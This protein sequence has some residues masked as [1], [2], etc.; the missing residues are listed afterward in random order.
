M[1]SPINELLDW[2]NA[3]GLAVKSLSIDSRRVSP[4]DVF[5]AYPGESSDGRRYIGQALER[6]A[7]AVLWD[8]E[9]FAWQA[10]IDFPQRPVANLRQAAGPLAH[11]IYGRPSEKLWTMG[12]TGTNGKTS[13]SQWL[14]QACEL[15][16]AH[17]AVIGTLGLGFPGE[18]GGD[19]TQRLTPVA[20]TTPDPVSLHSTFAQLLQQGGQGVAMEVSSIG[21]DQGRV[22]GVAFG[23][24][25]FTNLSRDHL[26]Y[27]GDMQSYARAKQKLFLTPGLRHAVLNL[28][29]VEGVHIARLLAGSGVNRIGYSCVDGV[30]AHA[31]LECYV[32]AHSIRATSQGT[33]FSVT[34]SWGEANMQ[35]VLL[36]RFNVANLAGVLGTM[37]GSGVPFDRAIDALQRMQPVV[38]RM[39]RL[40]GIDRPLVIVD[41]AHSPDSLEQTLQVLKEVARSRDGQLTVMFGCG[42]ERDRGKRALMGVVASRHADRIVVTSDNPRGEDPGAIIAEISKGISLAHQCIADRRAAIGVAVREAGAS[43]V[44][45]LAGKGH[46]AYQEIA[47]QRV[48][49]SDA[50][51]ATL[52]LQGWS[53]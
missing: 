43:D 31:G 53:R 4:G 47:G 12:V 37:L 19:A 41:Y 6:G 27:H 3:K 49:F 25:L 45:L 9:N 35:S 36:G 15:A 48:A 38:G 18:P 50:A 23:A 26:D 42:G 22:N 29:D 32:Q 7:A 2:F 13:C 30:A 1:A 5:L 11:Q 28:D 14:A 8:A 24:A 33:E 46:E 44:V 40:G 21:L 16:G 17:T 34:T 10:D 20:N 51:E 39:Q 52:A